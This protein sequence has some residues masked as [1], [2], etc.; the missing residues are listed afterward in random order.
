M[1]QDCNDIGQYVVRI[2]TP[3]KVGSGVLVKPD[4]NAKNCYI[5]TAK[6]LNILNIK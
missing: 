6:N 2:D 1:S 5:F 3:N 4:E